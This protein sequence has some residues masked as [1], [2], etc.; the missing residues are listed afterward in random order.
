MTKEIIEIIPLEQLG[1][2][3]TE[4][5]EHQFERV[6]GKDFPYSSWRVIFKKY[7]LHSIQLGQNDKVKFY[8]NKQE[9]L[10]LRLVEDWKDLEYCYL[11]LTDVFH[12]PS[13]YRKTKKE[14]EDFRKRCQD[15]IFGITRQIEE[16]QRT[17]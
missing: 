11:E 2:N 12:Y 1:Y 3:L 13:F 5:K 7:N 6:I 14:I 16:F 17:N 9:D 15:I 10:C 4:R 8:I